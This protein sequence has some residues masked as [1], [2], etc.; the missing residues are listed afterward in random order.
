MTTTK[1][2]NEGGQTSA[3]SKGK[4]ILS[5]EEVDNSRIQGLGGAIFGDSSSSGEEDEKKAAE[6]TGS[7][8]HEKAEGEPSFALGTDIVEHT[9]STSEEMDELGFFLRHLGGEELNEKKSL[10]LED[11]A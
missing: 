2:T 10:E 11:N 4:D 6:V 8:G 9:Q 7:L 3:S 1:G 5:K